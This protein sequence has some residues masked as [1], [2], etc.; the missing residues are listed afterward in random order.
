M[1]G[2]SRC[3]LSV[4]L[5]AALTQYSFCPWHQAGALWDGYFRLKHRAETCV[6][7]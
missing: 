1:Q 2:L 4:M 5:G 6:P 7:F 3:F